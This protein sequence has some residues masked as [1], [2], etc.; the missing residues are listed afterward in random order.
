M[1][2]RFY[3]IQEA[4]KKIGVSSDTLRRWDAKGALSPK[5]TPGGQRRYSEL[6][7][8][9][10]LVNNQE[11]QQKGGSD[12]K[13][14][15]AS[16]LPTLTSQPQGNGYAQFLTIQ[17]AAS[18]LGI[19]A[20]T[21]RRWDAQGKLTPIRTPGGQRRYSNEQLQKALGKNEEP[22]QKTKLAQETI[23]SVPQTLLQAVQPEQVEPLIPEPL[24]IE[25][26]ARAKA[27]TVFVK[28]NIALHF[29]NTFDAI[30]KTVKLFSLLL[31]VSTALVL[32]AAMLT[33]YTDR[34]DGTIAK[35]LLTM[36]GKTSEQEELMQKEQARKE[37]TRAVLAAQANRLQ[38]SGT[39][40]FNLPATFNEDVTA[41][42]VVY[43]VTGGSGITIAG[44]QTP[45]ITNTDLGSSQKI[46][47]NIKLGS[48]TATAASNTDTFEFAAGSNVSLSLDKTNKKLTI[49]STDTTGSGD[50][51]AVSVGNGL[52]GG[53]TSGDVTV[54]L[55]VTTTSTS[56]TTT[57]NSGLET[58]SSGLSLLR[59]C[60]DSQVLQW[61]ATNV[62][63]E[64]ASAGGAFTLAGDSGT[65][66]TISGSDTLTIA[67]GTNGIDTVASSTDTI[68]LNFDSTEVGT[69]TWGAGSAFTWTFDAGAT[70]PT[71]AFGS[72][73]ITLG[74]SVV[75][76]SGSADG[77]DALVLTAGDILV[78]NGDLDLSGGDFNVTLD[79]GDG[80]SITSAAAA[81]ADAFTTTLTGVGSDAL[82]INLTQSDDDDSTDNSA[83]LR[84]A[85]TSSSGDADLLYGIDIGNISEGTAIE[86]AMR[87]GSGWTNLIEF[88]GATNNDFEA[89]LQITDPT[90]DRTYTLPDA[91]GEICLVS[92]GNC[93]GSGT[94][95]T[96]TGGTEN[97]LAKF[98]GT[99]A[100]GNSTITDD[101]TSIGISIDVDITFIAGENLSLTNTSASTDQLNISVSGVTT[102]DAN[103]IELAFT[104]ADDADAGETNAAINVTVTGDSDNADTLIGVNIA[105]LAGASAAANSYALQI[106]SGW[107]SN[108]YFND[109]TSRV[110]LADGGTI[111]IHDG[112]NTL[113]TITDNVSVGDLTC[114]GSI[115][116]GT[117]GTQGHWS[118]TS[119]TLSPATANDIVSVSS[120]NNTNA[121]LAIT[122]NTADTIGASSA[123]GVVDFASTSLTTG[124]LLNLELT[125]GTLNGG[126]YLRAWDATAGS[127]VFSVGEDG[128]TTIAGLEGSTMFTLTAGDAAVSDGSL[129]IT[130]DDDAVSLGVTNNTATTVGAGVNTSGVID[131]SST[132][133]TTGNLLNLETTTALTSGRV[134]NASSTTTSSSFSGNI[135]RFEWLP[136]S[137]TTASADLLLIN[138]GANGTT[139]G[140]LLN[141][142]DAGS[143]LFS[144]SETALTSSLP[145]NFTAAGDVS[146]AYDI[147]FT[148]PTVSYI[149]SPS[150]LHIVSG[151][152]FNS[153]NLALQTYNA[154]S[155]TIS[156]VTGVSTSTT[157]LLRVDGTS[158]TSAYASLYINTVFNPTAASTSGYGIYNAFANTNATN[159]DT[160]Y[161]S[162]T[163]L[164]DAIALG[165][166]NY[167]DYITVSNTGALNAAATKTIYGQYISASGTGATTNASVATTVY[168][169]F[170]TTAA[171]HASDNGTVNN[172]VLYIDDG[173]SSTN[174][175][176]TKFGLY[177]EPMTAADENIGICF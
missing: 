129:S 52:S 165:N 12:S 69:T 49:T 144:V 82:Q 135:G 127:A 177:L 83:A 31:F 71:I 173:T 59:G 150:P 33:R 102:S 90:A 124:A 99:Q 11:A 19:S 133:L 45:T 21:L 152:P 24:F 174:G 46:F 151:E 119:T 106:G 176:N 138:I 98:T 112:T 65:S 163:T 104:Q 130:D 80:A 149:K 126:Y 67:G 171:T 131:F 74:S 155:V 169:I 140:N 17:E 81:T 105:N 26:L 157:G 58:A 125:E 51:T 162:Y 122:N 28:K 25:H 55:D 18:V 29:S 20:K 145:S 15:V 160:A 7:I 9:S 156:P 47:G 63:W 154:G 50:I 97:R 141:I 92:A 61:D 147:V 175:T 117:S 79:A 95:V 108:V 44:G 109:T 158:A 139:T 166:T 100:V 2:A 56:T 68:T 35:P 73:A 103:G 132:S 118:R 96:T 78:S 34:F 75:T 148:N 57:A 113:C 53:G 142:T 164:T 136:G 101:G 38:L 116:G 161:G 134:L 62:Y 93:A 168:G 153:S 5:R 115:T 42:N 30:P 39:I 143:S 16:E 60:S 1:P 22:E 94:G 48:D 146:I 88:E 85:L 87:F 172:Y 91:S 37:R 41:P 123:I 167:G 121:T 114:T 43:E 66:Q 40:A 3:T 23:G 70:D 86:V 170:A 72:N 120:N 27:K 13:L 6:Q 107:D 64:C 128:A 76:I 4:A 8:E 54:S 10:F 36:L 137:A 111:V 159:A 84:L 14:S 89:F 77:T 32:F 110:L